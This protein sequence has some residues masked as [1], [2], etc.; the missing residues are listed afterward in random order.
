VR[1]NACSEGAGAAAS[2]VAPCSPAVTQHHFSFT[3]HRH[4]GALVNINLS[5]SLLRS[6][7]TQVT[8]VYAYGLGPCSGTI[9][10]V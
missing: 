4:G 10:R 8:Y 6:R 7:A 1:L 9:A 5:G 2:Q 3:S